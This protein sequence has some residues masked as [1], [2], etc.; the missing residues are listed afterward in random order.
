MLYN[1]V[2]NTLEKLY[3]KCKYIHRMYRVLKQNMKWGD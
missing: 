3:K 2:Q 1:C